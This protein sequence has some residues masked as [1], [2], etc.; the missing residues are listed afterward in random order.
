[1][2][3]LSVEW[4]QEA[5]DIIDAKQQRLPSYECYIDAAELIYNYN[6]TE[7]SVGIATDDN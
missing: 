3:V 7:G 4:L 5:V 1:M 6:T 2:T